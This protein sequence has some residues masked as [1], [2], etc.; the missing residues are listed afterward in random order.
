MASAGAATRS[1]EAKMCTA[2]LCSA[3]ANC[4]S[5]AYTFA[6]YRTDGY[7]G[8]SHCHLKDKCVTSEDTGRT[9]SVGIQYR[10]F[11]RP[12]PRGAHRRQLATPHG[13]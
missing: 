5:F 1:K 10:T 2:A 11:Y 8:P 9:D 3:T 6:G 12:C 13:S 7:T 4:N